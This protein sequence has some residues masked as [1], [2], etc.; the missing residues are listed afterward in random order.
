MHYR[1]GDDPFFF[2]ALAN[3]PATDIPGKQVRL[4]GLID[5]DQP[6]VDSRGA[7]N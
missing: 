2:L 1:P 4:W 6:G 3:R 7:P 5:I